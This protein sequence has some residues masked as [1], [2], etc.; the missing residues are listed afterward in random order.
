MISQKEGVYNAVQAFCQE[1][2][3]QFEDGMKFTF[4]KDERATIIGMLV[5]ATEAGELEVKSSKAQSNL[6]KY[7]DGTLSNW[8]RKDLRLNG[9][10]PHQ[11]KNPGSR[12]GAG[13]P[14]LK[15]LKKLLTKVTNEGN[16]E[17]VEAVTQAIEAR[18]AAIAATK[19]KPVEINAELIPESL[20]DLIP[21]V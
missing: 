17:H 12:A 19:V 4:S 3:K 1:N 5:S 16:E 9:N 21:A 14:E 2:G 20:Q 13:D 15:E 6:K 7:W 10:V 8:L 18:K 11:I